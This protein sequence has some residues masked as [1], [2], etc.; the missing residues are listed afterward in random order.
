MNGRLFSQPNS[1]AQVGDV[2]LRGKL[3]DLSGNGKRES[4]PAR[5]KP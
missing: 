1:L 4:Y 5:R 3:S 2:S